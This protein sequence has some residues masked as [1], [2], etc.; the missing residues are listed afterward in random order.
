VSGDEEFFLAQV[1]KDDSHAQTSQALSAFLPACLG[2]MWHA[3]M[4]TNGGMALYKG[5]MPNT[6]MLRFHS[7][8][9][10]GLQNHLGGHGVLMFV[11]YTQVQHFETGQSSHHK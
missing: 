3:N 2:S 6:V 1:I 9:L 10:M 7:C 8:I 5:L 11:G 4:T